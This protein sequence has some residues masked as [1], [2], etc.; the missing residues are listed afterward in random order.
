[1]RVVVTKKLIF[2]PEIF[3]VQVDL[4][5][6][7]VVVN[8]MNIKSKYS[9]FTLI[10]ILL[11]IGIVTMVFGAIVP[12]AW[13]VIG[14]SAKGA[15]QREVYGNARF[16]SEKIKYEIRRASGI[17]SV[18]ANSISL[19]NFSPDTNTVID[20]S[21]GKVRINKNG[22]G[23][24]NLSSDGVTVSDLSFTNHTSV[25]NKTKNIS[26]TLTVDSVG[27]RQ[28]YQASVSLRGAAEIRSN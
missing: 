21:I 26:F 24:T 25:D 10:E 27:T 1:M 9:G 15:V 4:T 18:T 20:L 3:S 7:H 19:T 8:K 14:S 17:S 11:Y 16:I 12:F 23:A 22:G 2:H 13:N 6:I 5:Q 28:E